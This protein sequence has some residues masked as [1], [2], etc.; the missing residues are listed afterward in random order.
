MDVD[1]KV[2]AL[3]G[4]AMGNVKNR[5]Y[6]DVRENIAIKDGNGFFFVGRPDKIIKRGLDMC[7]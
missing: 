1:G 5:G 3:N 6:L 7:S 4:R 2:H